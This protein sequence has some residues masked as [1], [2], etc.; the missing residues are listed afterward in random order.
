MN[1]SNDVRTFVWPILLANRCFNSD[2]PGG[3]GRNHKKK[4]KDNPRVSVSKKDYG[5][6]LFEAPFPLGTNVAISWGVFTEQ[7]ASIF[8]VSLS[9]SRHK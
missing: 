6:I 8:V 5:A 4:R 7:C 3:G 9:E 2:K 1:I